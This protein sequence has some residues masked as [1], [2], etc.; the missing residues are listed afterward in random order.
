MKREDVGKI[1]EM[2][3]DRHVTQEKVT[4]DVIRSS[5]R[6]Y[7]D[8][9]DPERIYLI[10]NEIR[11]FL[12]PSKEQLAIYLEKYRNKDYSPFEE[13]Q[14][15]FHQAI[16]RARKERDSL[17]KVKYALF[18]EANKHRPHKEWGESFYRDFAQTPAELE[19]RQRDDLIAFIEEQKTL[20]GEKKVTRNKDRVLDLYE[21]ALE[22]HEDGYLSHD[23]RGKLLSFQEREH[24]FVLHVLKALAKSLDSH[25]KFFDESEA[26]DMRVRL[27][28]GYVGTGLVFKEGFE[29]PIISAITPNTPADKN[30]EIQLNDVLIAINEES[31]EKTS[32][33][34]AMDLLRGEENEPVVLTFKRIFKNGTEKVYKTAL[35]RELIT[36]E[37]D[38]VLTTYEGFGDGIIGTISLKSFYQN[39]NGISSES[40][41]RDAIHS[42]RQKGPLRGL[43]LDLR[44]NTGGYLSQAVKVAGL[45]ITN[46][47][48]VISKYHD[49]E[50]RVYRDLDEQVYYRG[51]MVVLTSK[52]TASAA[53][54]VA[55][56][57]QDYGI[58][59]V[60][61]DEQTYGKGS[62]QSQT[63]TD[64]NAASFFK[65]T[66]GK[67]YTVSGKTPQKQGVIADIVVPSRFAYGHL[68]EEF[69]EFPLE[70]DQIPSAFEDKL[71]DVPPEMKGWFIKYYLPTLQS[72]HFYWKDI[73]P[74]LKENSE[75][76]IAH[77]RDY[78]EFLE[79]DKESNSQ[80]SSV[81]PTQK[82]L[83]SDIQHL[84]A[85]NIIKDMF[86][87]QSK[88][89]HPASE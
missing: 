81:D 8:Q 14:A 39:K 5:L 74:K 79:N 73:V 85:V 82:F 66:V 29:G 49:G 72:R 75:Y 16:E 33:R 53:E 83:T 6:N 12:K 18:A 63:V 46:G 71:L 42:L 25:T 32:F 23:E 40:D 84:E 62:I 19:G 15:L 55:Q 13:M 38:R 76:R 11:P 50:I 78:Q 47:I 58:A 3:L 64:H 48:I 35:N 28:K 87:L 2:I 10:E 43:I 30:I 31:L 54:I 17:R 86:L 67:Y 77:N 57:L 22:S 45:F 68:G 9:F 65:V 52:M 36:V 21:I 37:E 88:I 56:A 26:F 59:L 24:R 20:Y 41:I 70:S 80:I 89:Q 34:K 51:P 69:L 44:D 61:G 60:V 7:I 4:P 1:M 27:E